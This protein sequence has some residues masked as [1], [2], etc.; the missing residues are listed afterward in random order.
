M[1]RG[2]DRDFS[3]VKVHTSSEGGRA[4]TKMGGRVP[5][6]QRQVDL[7][8]LSKGAIAH[9]A[10]QSKHRRAIHTGLFS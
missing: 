4:A 6:I 5:T 7:K 10:L 2:F 1:E 9:L 8:H 3:K